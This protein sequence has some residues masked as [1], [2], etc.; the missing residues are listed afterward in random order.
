MI[1]YVIIW[2]GYFIDLHFPTIILFSKRKIHRNLNYW[3][4]GDVIYQYKEL[5]SKGPL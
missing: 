1:V 4:I 3:H 2:A 5:S